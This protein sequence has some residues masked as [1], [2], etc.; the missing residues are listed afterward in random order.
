MSAL[1]VALSGLVWGTHAAGGADSYGY[2]SQAALWLDTDLVVD[3]PLATQV[4]WPDADATLAP[5]GYRPGLTPGTIVPTYAAGLPMLMALFQLVFGAQ[6]VFVVVP[7][8]GV[9]AVLAAAGLASRLS[10]PTAGAFAALLLASSPTV[11]FSVM[12]PMSDAAAAGWWALAMLW[13][14][15]TG[16]GSAGAAGAAA[17]V[18]VVTRPNLVGVAVAPFVYLVLRALDSDRRLGLLRL[19]LFSVLTAIGCLGV[20]AIH[21]YLY[22]SPFVSG[23]G[24][25]DGFFEVSRAPGNLA[26]FFLRPLAVE[27]ALSVLAC[28]GAVAL[29]G[30]SSNSKARVTGWLCLGV[31]G[32]VLASYLFF[33]TFPEWWYL[34][35]LVP[36]YPALAVLG[37]VG[38]V[39]V[40][41]RSPA[42]WRTSLLAAVGV[43]IVFVGLAQSVR[44]DVYRS[45]EY[46]SRYQTVG[47]FVTEELPPNAILFAFHESG[48]LRHYAGRMTVRFDILAPEWME[49]AT[50]ALRDAGYH[51]Y[52]VIEDPEAELFEERFAEVTPLGA[53]DWPA[54]ATFEGPVGVRIFDP[55][56]RQRQLNGEHVVTQ[57]IVHAP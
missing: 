1:W 44:R 28:A 3:Q 40:V 11:V 13:A 55:A 50:A 21:T 25:L 42:R 43:V 24:D 15:R 49:P 30:R 35:L 53:I 32:L 14:T 18:A 9:V 52:F 10:G 12:W 4:P 57:S 46:E 7:V 56:D 5:L 16:V 37:G 48:S 38:V 27:P 54:R 39:W 45:W 22:G 19:G 31:V 2:V 41:R 23:Y 20:A 26:G 34:R 17:A 36:A 29:L 6:A 33:Y 8:L 47:R 51:P